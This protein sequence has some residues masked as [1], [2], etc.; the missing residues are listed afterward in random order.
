MVFKRFDPDGGGCEYGEFSRAFY[1]RRS[2]VLCGGRA[3]Q[4]AIN[5]ARQLEEAH[6]E[7]R[8]FEAMAERR[9]QIKVQQHQ[10]MQERARLRRHTIAIS[11]ERQRAKERAQKMAEEEEKRQQR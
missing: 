6:R 11:I 8:A 10:E 5:R 3:Q 2:A 1:D 4:L 7:E 9:R